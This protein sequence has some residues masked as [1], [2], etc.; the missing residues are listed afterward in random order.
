MGRNDA[1]S[2]R[3]TTL[4]PKEHARHVVP[5]ETFVFTVIDGPDEGRSFR[6]DAAHPQR[7]LVGSDCSCDVQLEDT[8][9]SRRHM[10]LEV[11][12]EGLVLSDLASTNGT[13]VNGVVVREGLLRG[14]ERVVVGSTTMLVSVG[15][16]L[17]AL[18]L[19]DE[20]AF[21]TVIGASFEMQRLYPLCERLAASRVPVV[22]EGETGTGK[23]CLAESLHLRGQRAHQP[24]V[25]FDCTVVAPSL[26]ESELFGHE[27]GAFTGAVVSHQGVFERANGGTLLIDEVGE[28]PLSLQPKLLRALERSEV[29]RVGGNHWLKVDVRVLAATRRDLVQEVQQGRFRDD[30][31]H[32][33]AVTRVELPP[34]RNRIEDL[35]M[36]VAHFAVQQGTS[37]DA[38]PG[39]VVASWMSHSWPGNVRELRNAVMR[40][41]ALGDLDDRVQE[42]GSV[43]PGDGR[44][45][46]ETVSSHGDPIARILA[47]RLPLPEARQ[48]VIDEFESRYVEQLLEVYDGNVT[49]AAAASGVGRRYFQRLRAKVRRE[50][51]DAEDASR[52]RE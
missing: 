6:V 5:T 33:L 2:V 9:V 47:M 19:P 44:S 51:E 43:G 24:F 3:P 40:R 12:R 30:L 34:L 37:P 20:R 42:N 52:V 45:A 14:G 49:R 25:V 10:A 38:I 36:L 23:E 8:L 16:P 32:R 4:V 26:L 22:I 41:L 29:C 7:F 35:P 50:G 13:T 15:P 1:T 31:Y 17:H 21:G 46:V 27:R 48:V 18:L 39:E 28:L 11:T